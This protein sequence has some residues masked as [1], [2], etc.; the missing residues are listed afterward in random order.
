MRQKSH[1]VPIQRGNLGGPELQ[2]VEM[3]VAIS[4]RLVAPL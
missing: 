1:S 2:R 4:P 3:T